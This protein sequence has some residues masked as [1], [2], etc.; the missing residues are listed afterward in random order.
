M[1]LFHPPVNAVKLTIK[2]R[3][4][5]SSWEGIAKNQKHFAHSTTGIQNKL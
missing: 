3:L 4:N 2:L 1:R 5:V